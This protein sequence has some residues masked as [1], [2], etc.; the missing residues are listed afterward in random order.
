MTAFPLAI[1]VWQDLPAAERQALLQRP[2][3]S[4]KPDLTRAVSGIID[5]VRRDGDAALRRLT[6]KYDGVALESIRVPDADMAAVPSRLGPGVLPALERARQQI[7]TFHKAQRPVDLD[8]EVSPGVR[9]MRQSRPIARVGLYVPGGTAPLPSTVLMLAVPAALAGC[10]GR[11]LCTPPREDGSVD[12]AILAAASLCGIEQVYRV[13][14]A[15]AVAAMAFGTASVPAVDKIFGPGNAFVTEAKVQAARDPA[16]AAADMPAGP[17]EVLV[18]AD[19]QADPAFVAA[20]LLSQAEHGPDSQCVL[21]TDSRE[22]IDATAVALAEQL[23]RLSRSEYAALSLSHSFAVLT[24]DTAS[25]LEFS[26]AWAPEHLIIQTRDAAE[27]VPHVQ[28]AG[29]VFLGPWSPESVGDYASGTNHVLPTYGWTR[30]FSGLSLD[31]FLKQ[32][33]FQQLTPGGLQD[34]G[35]VVEELAALEG[36]D[37]HKNAVSLRLAA[38]GGPE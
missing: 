4:Q 22:L 34:I 18:L 2:A 11:V 8:L 13:G 37:A 6:E 26:N 12:P 30:S 28:N 31:S 29:S 1:K 32:I 3:L 10:P 25:S 36:L 19:G 33:T 23:E 16:G 24:A 27:L 14:G 9:C 38:I 7:E 21:V 5:A 35:P 20:D 15:Q 17:S